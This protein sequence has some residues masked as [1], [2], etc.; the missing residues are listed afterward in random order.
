[1]F[2]T[3]SV[4]INSGAR[5]GAAWSSLNDARKRA[6]LTKQPKERNEK[7]RIRVNVKK[8]L[9]FV[10]KISGLMHTFWT[11]PLLP[12][13][14]SESQGIHHVLSQ[15]PNSTKPYA[16]QFKMLSHCNH[17]NAVANGTWTVR[18][19][20]SENDS[21]ARI[22]LKGVSCASVVIYIQSTCSR[23]VRESS[24]WSVAV[25]SAFKAS[26][27]KEGHSKYH[28]W[29]NNGLQGHWY[30]RFRIFRGL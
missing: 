9:T 27:L 21:S 24:A 18:Y 14:C 20:T 7:Y 23:Q 6:T 2:I 15:A 29:I 22:S 10:E 3:I 8:V 30:I 16:T 17:G 11:T 25:P 5:S 4:P 1:M 19:K 12:R 26:R 28:A 13:R